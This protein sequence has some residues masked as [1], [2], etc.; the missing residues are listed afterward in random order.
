MKKR[1][2]LALIF[3]LLLLGVC[4]CSSDEPDDLHTVKV[5]VEGSND[6]NIHIQGVDQYNETGVW[7]QCYLERTF[8]T[9]YRARTITIRCDDKYNL[10]H[11]MVWYD[12]R[13]I[14]DLIG[15]SY[16]EAGFNLGKY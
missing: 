6:A 5:I 8:T 9:E 11:V 16:I 1:L 14:N 12:G 13:L 2:F 7:F 10:I 15:N 4:A 3:S